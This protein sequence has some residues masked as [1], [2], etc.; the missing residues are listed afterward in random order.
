MFTIVTT[1]FVTYKYFKVLRTTSVTMKA[2]C[3]H[4]ANLAHVAHLSP[5]FHF[6]TPWKYHKTT[7]F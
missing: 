4:L 7:D 1:S 6:Y 2:C 5:M 3:N